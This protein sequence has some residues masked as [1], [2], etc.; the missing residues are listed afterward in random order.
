MDFV[1]RVLATGIFIVENL[2]HLNGFNNEVIALVG[3]ALHPLPLPF[4][5]SLHGFMIFLGLFGSISFISGFRPLLSLALR[6]L[7]LFMIIVTWV[8][9]FRRFGMFIWE[10]EQDDERR[11]RIVHC[12]KNLSIFGF[13]IL[14][15]RIH[16]VSRQGDKMD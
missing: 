5:Y 15:S 6:S 3:P 2:N 9:W 8:W 16:P 14:V 10:V 1:S 7:G 12:L 4:A 11:M 13:I